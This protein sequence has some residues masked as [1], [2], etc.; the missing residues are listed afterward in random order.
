MGV[1]GPAAVASVDM[2]VAGIAEPAAVASV[3]ERTGV[4]VGMGDLSSWWSLRCLAFLVRLF[5]SLRRR[6]LW[7]LKHRRYRH[8]YPNQSRTRIKSQLEFE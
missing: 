1:A 7:R 5:R 4:V 8:V 2:G 3:D 6:R